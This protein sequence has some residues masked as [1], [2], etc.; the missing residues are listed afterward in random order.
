[1]CLLGALCVLFAGCAALSCLAQK[2]AVIETGAAFEIA[3]V[4]PEEIRSIHWTHGDE[5]LTV[6]RTG[7]VWVL[8][9]EPSSP[10]RQDLIDEMA[11]S[12]AS[13]RATRSVAEGANAADYGLDAPR[14][15][16]RIGLE[17]GETLRYD[18]GAQNAATGEYYL[19][20][21]EN[22]A[23]YA[24]TTPLDSLFAYGRE[25]L[26]ETPKMP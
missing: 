6:C 19:R 22:E 8:E 7:D 13:L 4:S 25:E 23:V 15:S 18:M 16:V 1:M 24:I 14:Y 5:T 9:N 21:S 20:F 11:C 17:S 2:E 3:G 26:L 12:I 10:L